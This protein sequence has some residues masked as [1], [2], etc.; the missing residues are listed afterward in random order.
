M[1]KSTVLRE[2]SLDQKSFG[3]KKFTSRSDGFVTF[4]GG[5]TLKHQFVPWCNKLVRLPEK[6]FTS[7]IYEF[8]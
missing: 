3:Q 4:S 2:M 8:L 5:V 6:L 7:E 1:L